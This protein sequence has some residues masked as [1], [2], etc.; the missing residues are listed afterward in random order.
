M[1]NVSNVL[2]NI[3]LPVYRLDYFFLKAF[4]H[5]VKG[6]NVTNILYPYFQEEKLDKFFHAVT[7]F[8][9]GYLEFFLVLLF[10]LLFLYDK[11]KFKVCKEYALSLILV[12]C[13]TQVVVNILKLTFGR[14]RPYVFFDPE[15]FYGIFYL[16]DNHLLMNSQYHSFPSGHTITI[17]GTIWFFFFTVKSK[18]RYLLFSLGFLVALSR[19]YLGYHWFSDV[20]VSIGLSYVIVKWIVTKRSVMR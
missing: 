5:E 18:Y 14:A 9:E 20:T 12:L 8:G 4:C 16:I 13:S 15:R 10:F 3:L 17:W 7:H 19:M 1:M 11:K 2:E 6:D